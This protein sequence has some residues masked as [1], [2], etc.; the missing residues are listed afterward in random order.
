M[1]REDLI[2]KL[3]S[4]LPAATNNTVLG[5]DAYAGD[6]FQAL[7]F[8]VGD[9]KVLKLYRCQTVDRQASNYEDEMAALQTVGNLHSDLAAKNIVVPLLHGHGSFAAPL[10]LAGESF[11]AWSLMTRVVG[12]PIQFDQRQPVDNP[13]TVA[14]LEQVAIAAAH[15]HSHAA[16]PAKRKRNYALVPNKRII[17]GVILRLLIKQRISYR[18]IELIMA[19]M[20][21]VK[22]GSLKKSG[23]SRCFLHGDLDVYNIYESGQTI[24]IID[25]S[26]CRIGYPERD[27]SR[28]LWWPEALPRLAESYVRAGGN[29]LDYNLLYVLA[30]GRC[31][32]RYLKSLL[33]NNAYAAIQHRKNLRQL[34][35]MLH[36]QTG[37][38]VYA[39]VAALPVETKL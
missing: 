6:G 31:L 23:Q 29:K 20:R 3:N 25:W 12:A 22:I 33:R 14:K 10:V 13:V 21:D 18:I 28:F 19:M 11:F 38:S 26:N 9:D 1:S 16:P 36:T 27:L 30:A 35:D 17:T 7:C 4:Y 5:V 24:G 8:T 37:R 39:M 2:A 15:I 32:F 34:C